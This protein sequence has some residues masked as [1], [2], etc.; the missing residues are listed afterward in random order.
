[1]Y[2]LQVTSRMTS[3]QHIMN[4]YTASGRLRLLHKFL[5]ERQLAGSGA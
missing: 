2:G 3:R 4:L 1:M 5:P